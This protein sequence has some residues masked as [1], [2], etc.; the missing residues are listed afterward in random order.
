MKP[1]YRLALASALALF[2]SACSQPVDLSAPEL[3][4][5]YGTA[6]YDRANHVASNSSG[7]LYTLGS[8]VN[9]ES[10]G[11][12]SYAT[13]VLTRFDRSGKMIWSRNTDNVCEDNFRDYCGVKLFGL[14]VDDPG[15]SYTFTGTYRDEDYALITTASLRKYDAAGTLL[16][17]RSVYGGNASDKSAMTTTPTGESYVAFT[18][19]EYEAGYESATRVLRKYGPSGKLLWQVPLSITIP[20]DVAVSSSG[21]VYVAGADGLAKYSARGAHIWT[22]ALK[23]ESCCSGGPSLAISSANTIYLQGTM[24]DE[25]MASAF[26]TLFK[27]DAAG[28]QLWQRRGAKED[29]FHHVSADSSGNAYV[30]GSVTKSTTSYDGDYLVRKYT[31][32]G[33]VAWTSTVRLP[34]T[35]EIALGVTAYSSNE[36]Y[37]VGTTDGKVNGKN[38]GNSDAFLLRLDG[39]GKRVWSR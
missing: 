3:E 39:Q 10:P 15:N 35:W 33:S 11:D 36:I 20:S 17:Q 18:A 27:Y 28:R 24:I 5:Q 4:P 9:S 26:G 2:I 34:D 23:F 30:S 32:A 37:A 8:A 29:L 38:F 19:Y 12:I 6:N 16:W 7:F 22:R 14:G 21:N 1:C 31:P 25:K 13:S